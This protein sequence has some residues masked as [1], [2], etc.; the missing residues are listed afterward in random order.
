MS[1][2]N[3]LRRLIGKTEPEVRTLPRPVRVN[4]AD[5]SIHTGGFTRYLEWDTYHPVPV[6]EEI[7][8]LLVQLRSIENRIQS[9]AEAGTL[10]GLVPDLLDR[11]IHNHCL[12]IRAR[13]DAALERNR[14]QL[15]EFREQAECARTD[16]LLRVEELRHHH[17]RSV[18]EYDKAWQELTGEPTATPKPRTARRIPPT[19]LPPAP[20]PD[21]ELFRRDTS[22]HSHIHTTHHDDG[23]VVAIDR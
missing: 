21:G 12:E 19:E 23:T 22:S 10:D 1:F 5:H 16:L 13:I 4:L 7:P 11:E 20:Q 3:W 2:G 14:R 17:A 15:T 18:R 8:D 9:H 6:S